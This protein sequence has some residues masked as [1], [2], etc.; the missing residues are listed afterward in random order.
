[1][2]EEEDHEA[3]LQRQARKCFSCDADATTL[4]WYTVGCYTLNGF[5]KCDAH[6]E[7]SRERFGTRRK[8]EKH[9]W[10]ERPRDQADVERALADLR[11]RY[12][13]PY[14]STV[15]EVA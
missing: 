9:G 14:R 6:A 5:P 1:M 12:R 15:G 10:A 3:W 11:Q 2:T 13:L 4:V 7:D 8:R